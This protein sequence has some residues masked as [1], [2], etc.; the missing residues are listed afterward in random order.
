[1]ISALAY[2]L[3]PETFDAAYRCCL[4]DYAG[5]PLNSADFQR[6]CQ[7]E[8]GQDLNGFFTPW[9]RTN[10]YL[11]YEIVSQDI[12]KKGDGFEI[13]EKTKRAETLRMSI[14]VTAYFEDGSSQVQ[15]TN[16]LL[17]ESVVTF[18]RKSPLKEIKLDAQRELPLVIPPPGVNTDRLKEEIENLDWTGSGEK[19]LAAFKKMGK[20]KIGDEALLFKLG[21]CLYDAKHYE[22]A[23]ISFEKCAMLGKTTDKMWLFIGAA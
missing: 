18:S 7:K 11:S 20:Q 10:Q 21:M 8:S 19:A 16:R 15:Y 1:M 13:E 17:D 9:V 23:A 12:R 3:G 5:Q 6:I 4:K 14:P 2:T 22:E